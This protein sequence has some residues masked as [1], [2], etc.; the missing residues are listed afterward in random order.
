MKP[1]HILFLG[2]AITLCSCDGHVRS[3]KPVSSAARTG[4]S[5]PGEREKLVDAITEV[6]SQR[7]YTRSEPTSESQSYVVIASFY[8]R[9]D[10]DSVQMRLVQ[11]T[12]TGTYRIVIIDWPS[13]TRST[14]SVAAEA[15]IHAKLGER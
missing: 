10:R 7:G 8:K 5:T 4:S 13:F 9:V 2:L 11:D 14:E 6:A 12:K 15:A 1:Q 3:F